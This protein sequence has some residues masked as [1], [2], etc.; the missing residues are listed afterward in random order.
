MHHN[1]E[2]ALLDPP[3]ALDLALHHKVL[4]RIRGGDEVEQPLRDLLAIASTAGM[5]RCAEKI[6]EMQRRLG[7]AGG[8][9]SFWS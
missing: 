5:D 8:Y 9:T 3:R 1:A 6:D 7:E 2:Q 4:P